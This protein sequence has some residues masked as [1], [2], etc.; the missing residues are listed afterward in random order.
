MK[1]E[2]LR[3]SPG[4]DQLLALDGPAPAAGERAGVVNTAASHGDRVTVPPLSFF[5]NRL[6]GDHWI[7]VRRGPAASR[8]VDRVGGGAA[9]RHW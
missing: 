5:A 4:T 2:P 1:L 8:T 6:N 3:L 7:W 9:D